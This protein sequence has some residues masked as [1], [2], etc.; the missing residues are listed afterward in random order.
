MVVVFKVF[1]FLEVVGI[2]KLCEMVDG[3]FDCLNVRSKIEYVR[4][5]KFFLVLYIL[6]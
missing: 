6:F 4:K 2:V 5:R 3:F 1:G